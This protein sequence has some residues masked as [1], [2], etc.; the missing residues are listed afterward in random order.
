M[1]SRFKVSFKRKHK[2]WLKRIGFKLTKK[3]VIEITYKEKRFLEF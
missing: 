3:K 1:V 2:L